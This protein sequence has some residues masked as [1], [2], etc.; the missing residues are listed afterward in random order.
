MIEQK[1]DSYTLQKVIPIHAATTMGK[2]L[3]KTANLN[4]MLDF[5]HGVVGLQILQQ[6]E[7]KILL[8]TLG[9]A[10]IQLNADADAI[11]QSRS[12]TGLYHTAILFPDK[13]S[14]AMK[15]Y[16]LADMNIQFGYADHLVSEAFYLSDPDGNGVE[17]YHDRP[18][19]EWKWSNGSVRMA[20][21]AI[22]FEEFFSV[23]TDAD[24]HSP[25]SEAPEG[26]R[27]G[28]VHLKVS[29]ISAAEGFYHEVLGFD[30][31]AKLPG[32]LFVS[33]G[34]YHH[35]IGMN[36]WESRGGKPQLN[37]AAGLEEVNIVVPTLEEID[38]L[39]EQIERSGISVTRTMATAVFRDPFSIQIRLSTV[40]SD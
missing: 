4:P 27:V 31:T 19:S 39:A 24:R 37:P 22:D 29:D 9:H 25:Q 5:Y 3:L 16:Q 30:I 2:V 8:G 11:L 15:V 35:H 12:A 28:H 17:L 26:T 21:D 40:L 34:G 33:A 23:I 32:A 18:R 14:L 13:R 10:V 6:A 36:T 38:R 20:S 1:M 7:N